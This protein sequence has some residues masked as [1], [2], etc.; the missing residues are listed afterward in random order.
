MQT[1]SSDENSV[2]PSVKHVDCDKTE[3]RF[4]QIFI[5]YERSFS[6]VFWE[7]WLVG[8]NPF[9]LKFFVNRPRCSTIAD[10]QPIIDR[11]ASAVTSSE[12][13][14]INT[15][16][17]KSTTHFPMSLRWSSYVA[18]KP[19]NGGGAQKCKTDVF[20]VKSHFACRTCATKFLCVKTVSNKVVRH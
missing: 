11:S 6:L 10:F 3:E 19:P 14:S 20:G 4:V 7:E 9:Y 15:N 5:S 2:C 16:N 13:S 12:K 18:H 8:G 1:W 17:R